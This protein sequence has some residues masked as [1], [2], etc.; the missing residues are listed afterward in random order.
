MTKNLHYNNICIQK[1]THVNITE[2]HDIVI[3]LQKGISQQ[4]IAESLNGSQSTIS[5]EIK[6]NKILRVYRHKKAQCITKARQNNNNN[7]FISTS[8]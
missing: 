4:K 6:R 2:R 8:S 3:K 1:R 7:S 5:R